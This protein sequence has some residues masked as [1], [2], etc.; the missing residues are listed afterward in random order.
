[1]KGSWRAARASGGGAVRLIDERGSKRRPLCLRADWELQVSH[2][3]RG[4]A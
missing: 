2:E 4:S 1:M 3:Q